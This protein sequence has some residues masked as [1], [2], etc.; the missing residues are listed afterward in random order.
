MLKDATGPDA[1]FFFTLLA[2]AAEPPPSR[3]L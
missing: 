3:S 1:A 2:D